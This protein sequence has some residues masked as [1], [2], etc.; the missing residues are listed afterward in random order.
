M[1]Y[2]NH[3]YKADPHELPSR[4]RA[5]Y[6]YLKDR[7]GTGKECWPSVNTI[8]KDLALSDR[9]IQ[10]AMKD[11]EMAGILQKEARFRENGSRTSS[12]L[13]LSR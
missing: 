4:A 1:P 11:L 2:F 9:T 6:M 7:T 3:L 8:A 13:H 10:R 5:V 12:L